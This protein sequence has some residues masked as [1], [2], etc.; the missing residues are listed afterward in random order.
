[1]SSL[2]TVRSLASIISSDV[3]KI[4]YKF[5]EPWERTRLRLVELNSVPLHIFN[6]E[7]I[8]MVDLNSPHTDYWLSVL[9]GIY[10]F[11][12]GQLL[13]YIDIAGRNELDYDQAYLNGLEKAW[14]CHA[15]A[16]SVLAM[17]GFHQLNK[18]RRLNL[19]Y[20][21]VKTDDFN[22]LL[23]LRLTNTWSYPLNFTLSVEYELFQSLHW[24]VTHNYK[25]DLSDIIDSTTLPD[26]S[27]SP[28]YE[29]IVQGLCE[30]GYTEVDLVY[31]EDDSADL[32]SL[33]YYY[34]LLAHRFFLDLGEHVMTSCRSN[35]LP[36][37]ITMLGNDSMPYVQASRLHLLEDL[38]NC[39]VDE[40]MGLILPPTTDKP[41]PYLDQLEHFTIQQ[42]TNTFNR[43][44]H[45]QT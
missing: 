6:I 25:F 13:E 33:F 10:P 15:S 24:L 20:E 16:R 7:R 31:T 35:V 21:Q 45:T 37:L 38:I 26:W 41:I 14:F 43:L 12:Y 23:L 19:F 11:V 29:P 17:C 18:N 39:K 32:S 40:L 5:L 30:F 1:M 2:R 28:W 8:I 42:V 22:T 4:V 27:S 34:P 9:R 44:R 36:T 3:I